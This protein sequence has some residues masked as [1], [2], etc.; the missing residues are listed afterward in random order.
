MILTYD[1]ALERSTNKE[2]FKSVYKK[3]DVISDE[4]V[5]DVNE[6]AKKAGPKALKA[7]FEIDDD[8]FLQ[9]E[10]KEDLITFLY[11]VING[12]EKI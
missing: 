4:E 6:L 5:K 2:W 7:Y 3:E 10:Y 12:V 11:D 9:K 8:M 1:E